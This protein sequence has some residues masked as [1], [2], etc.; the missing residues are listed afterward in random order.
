MAHYLLTG[1]E[2]RRR[3]RARRSD[4]R[5]IRPVLGEIV[6]I[7]PL[8]LGL[9]SSSPL[10]VG[11]SYSFLVRRGVKMKRVTGHVAWSRLTKTE[12]LTTTTT[13]MVYRSGIE[14][15]LLQP[16]TWRFLDPD[17]NATRRARYRK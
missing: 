17:I 2:A 8:G 9:E 3:S 12:L 14:I 7:S 4:L 16:S 6:D 1:E 13:K 10:R 15:D 5:L 11:Q